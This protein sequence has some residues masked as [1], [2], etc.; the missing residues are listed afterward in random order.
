MFSKNKVLIIFILVFVILAIGWFFVMRPDKNYFGNNKGPSPYQ[1]EEAGPSDGERKFVVLGASLAKANNLSSGLVGDHPEYSFASGSKIESL[2]SYL[3]SKGENLTAANLAESGVNS[4]NILQKQVPNAID[5]HPK[6]LIVDI[7]ADILENNSPDQLKNNLAEI[8]A[9]VKDKDTIVL[10]GSYFNLP[11]MRAAP[12]PAC[13][14]DKLRVGF[15]KL[16]Q[17]KILIFN[18]AIEEAALKNG[19]IFVDIYNVLGPEDV[20]DYDCVHPN[21][22]G[23]KKLA[24]AWI[25][26]LEE[27]KKAR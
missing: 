23:Q 11:K 27:F 5:F 26:A 1:K 16:T 8:T 20:S 6:Y 22:N 2:F 21:I 18:R 4:Q 24:Q 12:Y 3:K 17:E 25:G 19:A 13:K 14:E 15:D 9:R 7:A 10:F